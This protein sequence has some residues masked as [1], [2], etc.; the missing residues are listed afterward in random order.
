MNKKV[1]SKF[2]FNKSFPY[3]CTT[4][5]EDKED[6]TTQTTHYLRMAE[7]EDGKVVMKCKVI[8]FKEAEEIIK[9]K[10]QKTK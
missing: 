3:I 2:G 5:Q 7:V 8:T 6:M 1:W 9:L 10:L 4:N